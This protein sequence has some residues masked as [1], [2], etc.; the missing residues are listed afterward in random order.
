MELEMKFCILVSIFY[1]SL[2]ILFYLY[3]IPE[4]YQMEGKKVHGLGGYVT[5]DSM[6]E[7]GV[8]YKDN[9]E[10]QCLSGVCG[11]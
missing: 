8:I 11:I 7:R 9:S 1:L 10:E 2:G 6:I 5:P 3:A 4:G